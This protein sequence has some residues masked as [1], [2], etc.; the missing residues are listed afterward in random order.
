[1]SFAEQHAVLMANASGLADFWSVAFAKLGYEMI[2][3]VSNAE[4]M[5]KAWAKENGFSYTKNNWLL[6]I[7]TAQ[8]LAFKPDVLFVNDHVTFSA[9]YLKYLKSA[10][11]S[12]RLVLGWCGAP[13]RDPSVFK[14]YDIVLSSAPELVQHFIDEGHRSYLI[15]HAFDPRIL[16]K[17]GHANPTPVDLAFVGTLAK[18][19]GFH[20]EREALLLHLLEKTPLQVW[21][22]LAHDPYRLRANIRSR[23]WI[24]DFVHAAKRTGIPEPMLRIG[25]LGRAL[26]W[27]GRPSLPPPFD[28]RLVRAARP[29]LFGLEMFAQLAHSR[30]TINSHIDMSEQYAS[31]MR[32]YEATGVGSCLLTDWRP[33]LPELF[34]PDTEV[35]TYRTAEECV[36]KVNYLLAHEQ[37]RQSISRAGQ[38]RTLRDHTYEHRA[39]ELTTILQQHLRG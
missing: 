37:E 26:S 20:R 10:C 12:I 31:N 36:E 29:P 39:Y 22:M 30:I 38:R 25:L 18:K 8:A 21:A 9:S 28:P 14:E 6:E 34:A 1:M 33:N 7:T 19:Q 15:R 13:Y 3:V 16:S 35:I 11:P 32:L 5:Q 4:T 17:L 24:Y 23:Q 2:D 27:K